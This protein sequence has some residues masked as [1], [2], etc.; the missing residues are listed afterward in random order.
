MKIKKRVPKKKEVLEA[1]EIQG[2]LR[3]VFSKAK[4]TLERY[5]L[6]VIAL[7]SGAI[8]LI[9]AVAVYYHLTSGSEKEASLLGYKAYNYYTEGDY[10]LA[11]SSFQ[12]IIN[13]YSRSSSAPIALYYSG[14]SYLGLGQYEEA[15]QAYR[16]FAEKYPGQEAILPLVYIN[17]GHSYMNKKDYNNAISAFKQVLTLKDSAISDRAVYETAR[18]YEASGD[19]LSAVE[20]YEYLTKTYPASPWSQDAKA[21]LDKA[22]GSSNSRP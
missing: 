18:A 4:E 3:G 20:R 15:I 19:N 8:I 14:N 22:S 21:K 16:K 10:N 13:K 5:R 11:L 12:E 17:L 6:L 2:M 7:L 1:E 9:I